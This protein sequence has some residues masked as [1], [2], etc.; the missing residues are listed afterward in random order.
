M[1]NVSTNPPKLLIIRTAHLRFTTDYHIRLYH[2]ESHVRQ[3]CRCSKLNGN[4]CGPSGF[5]VYQLRSTLS[6]RLL[7]CHC[8]VMNSY[9]VDTWCMFQTMLALGKLVSLTWQTQPQFCNDTRIETGIFSSYMSWK[10]TSE[11]EDS[12]LIYLIALYI[13]IIIY[14]SIYIYIYIHTLSQI[15]IYTWI[16]APTL[17]STGITAAADR[18]KIFSP[19]TSR[20]LDIASCRGRCPVFLVPVTTRYDEGHSDLMYIIQNRNMDELRFDL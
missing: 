10:W 4:D 7:G 11:R 13:Y 8:T 12:S 9:C 1:Y 16:N 19:P 6:A 18:L 17:T 3:K 14:Y 20:H 2:F 5:H 15:Y